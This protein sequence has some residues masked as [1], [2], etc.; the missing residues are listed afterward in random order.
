MF[1]KWIVTYFT[2]MHV[3]IKLSFVDH[4]SIKLTIAQ[5]SCLSRPAYLPMH[6]PLAA[7]GSCMERYPGD[8]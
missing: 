2:Q 7:E 6:D 4:I 5:I 1:V 3:F 8:G